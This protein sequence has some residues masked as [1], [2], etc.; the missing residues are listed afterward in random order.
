ME[1]IIKTVLKFTITIGVLVSFSFSTEQPAADQLPDWCG[2]MEVNAID[3]IYLGIQFGYYDDFIDFSFS[4]DDEEISGDR[5]I[6]SKRLSR[7]LNTEDSVFYNFCS[8]SLSLNAGYGKPSIVSTIIGRANIYPVKKDRKWILISCCKN[9]VCLFTSFLRV[10]TGVSYSVGCIADIPKDE[11]CS[12]ICL[13]DFQVEDQVEMLFKISD[14][15]GV[16]WDGELVKLPIHT[17]IYDCPVPDDD[18]DE[19]NE[20]T[21][22]YYYVEGGKKYTR[23][24]NE[25]Q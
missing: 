11:Y 7:L 14:I 17:L 4:V 18:E 9:K 6:P 24:W 25:E 2:A 20:M 8:Q 3:S 15:Y 12:A 1:S 23:F 19:D 21:P 5:I 13:G 16:T 22:Y 10:E